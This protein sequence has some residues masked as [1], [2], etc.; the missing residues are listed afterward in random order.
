MQF[1]PDPLSFL[2]KLLGHWP[3]KCSHAVSTPAAIA[4][5]CLCLKFSPWP[6]ASLS[7]LTH[8]FNFGFN[9]AY[10]FDMEFQLNSS[11]YVTRRPERY[12]SLLFLFNILLKNS[13]QRN[14]YQRTCLVI[15]T[16]RVERFAIQL[17]KI[18]Y[19]L[20]HVQTICIHHMPLNT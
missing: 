19:T 13:Q 11:N 5:N 7:Y 2:I 16:G 9:N 6:F 15:L 4:I 3:G 20:C 14:D 12:L 17:N 1:E 10:N 8:T 18:K